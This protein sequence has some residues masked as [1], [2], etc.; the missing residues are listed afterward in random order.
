MIMNMARTTTTASDTLAT[1]YFLTETDSSSSKDKGHGVDPYETFGET[2]DGKA[3]PEGDEHR[4]DGA[5][6]RV[7]EQDKYGQ[8]G[9]HHVRREVEIVAQQHLRNHKQDV[10]KN[11]SVL[12][13]RFLLLSLSSLVCSSASISAARVFR[14]MVTN[15]SAV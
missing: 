7:D 10:S 2:V 3:C 5:Y 4:P 1:P 14:T 11:M 15:L 13:H 9:Q 6:L 8:D 12:V